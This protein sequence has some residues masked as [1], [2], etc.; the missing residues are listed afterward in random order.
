MNVIHAAQARNSAKVELAGVKSLLTSL[1]SSNVTV[2]SLMT[3]RHRQV[4]EYMKKEKPNINHQLD[5][6]Y[7][8]KNMKKKVKFL[9]QKHY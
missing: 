8:G 6:W 5:I 1:E 9:D 2:S 3:N 4:R 7:V